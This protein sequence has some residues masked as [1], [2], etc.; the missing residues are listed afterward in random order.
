MVTEGDHH[1][2]ADFLKDAHKLTDR[3][4]GAASGEGAGG[5]V[6]AGENNE[7]AGICFQ[8]RF[9]ERLGGGSHEKEVLDITDLHN[10]EFAVFIILQMHIG[11]FARSCGSGEREHTKHHKNGKD[12]G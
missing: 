5:N 10:G 9:Q 4:G 11:F 8:L 7:I 6:I 1:G 12:N 2:S 3:H